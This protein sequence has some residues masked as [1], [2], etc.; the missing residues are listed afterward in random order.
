MR[1]TLRLSFRVVDLTSLF[2]RNMSAGRDN[3]WGGGR[4]Q[5]AN[6]YYRDGWSKAQ[7]TTAAQCH[8]PAAQ[9]TF[10][11]RRGWIISERWFEG[12]FSVLDHVPGLVCLGKGF[13]PMLVPSPFSS[14]VETIGTV[15]RTWFR[16]F[17]LEI[18]WVARAKAFLAEMET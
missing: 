7:A 9:H 8:Q 11:G 18:G 2:H 5:E 16:I 4:A 3:F 1:K 15:G 12:P 10:Y 14:F 17:F 6:Y 13:G